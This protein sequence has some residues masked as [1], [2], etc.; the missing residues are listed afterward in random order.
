MLLATVTDAVVPTAAESDSMFP[1]YNWV[2]IGGV[3]AILVAYKMFKN[4]TMT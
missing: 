1:W 3:I 4:K 2:F